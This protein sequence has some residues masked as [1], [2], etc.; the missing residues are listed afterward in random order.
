MVVDLIFKNRII[1]KRQLLVTFQIDFT[2]L[3]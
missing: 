1:I 2:Y 3:E